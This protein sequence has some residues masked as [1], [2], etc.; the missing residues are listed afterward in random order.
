MKVLFTGLG[1]IARRHV[2][3]L[4]SLRGNAVHITVLRSAQGQEAP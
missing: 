3:N 1:S 2:R 4:R